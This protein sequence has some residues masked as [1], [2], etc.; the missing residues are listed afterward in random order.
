MIVDLVSKVER[1][2]IHP[3]IAQ[4]F[5]WEDAHKGFQALLEQTEVGKIV[6]KV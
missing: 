5:N 2:D 3:T 4:V 1:F 6:I